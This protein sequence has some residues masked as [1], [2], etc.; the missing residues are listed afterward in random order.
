M[1]LNKCTIERL[2]MA[3][4]QDP[5]LVTPIGEVQNAQGFEESYLIDLGLTHGDIIKLER[6]GMALRCRTKNVYWPES[7]NDDNYYPPVPFTETEKYADDRGYERTRKRVYMS[8]LPKSTQ[9]GKG[10]VIRWILTPGRP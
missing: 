7:V 9:R 8:R 6:F 4:G 1:K 10:S 5:T 3:L 2:K